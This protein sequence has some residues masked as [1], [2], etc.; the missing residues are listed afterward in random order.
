MSPQRKCT[1][2]FISHRP[3]GRIFTYAHWQTQLN[4]TD[5]LGYGAPWSRARLSCGLAGKVVHV[6]LPLV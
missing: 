4:L 1:C 6:A 3:P 2:I 5:A